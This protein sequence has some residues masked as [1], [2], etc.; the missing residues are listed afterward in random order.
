V[1]RIAPSYGR[2]RIGAGAGD[3]VEPCV[4]LAELLNPGGP[5]I[6]GPQNG[7]VYAVA[8]VSY[9]RARIG[10]GAGDGTVHAAGLLD[11]GGSP[12]RGVQN[13]PPHCS[14]GI[15]VGARDG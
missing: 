6:C 7:P 14:A 5:A 4:P 10:V 2:A 13:T 8:I 15:G 11:P 1:R 3:A 12:I 9:G